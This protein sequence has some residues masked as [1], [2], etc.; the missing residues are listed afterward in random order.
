MQNSEWVNLNIRIKYDAWLRV[1]GWQ[2]PTFNILE[3]SFDMLF[4]NIASFVSTEKTIT[5]EDT[6]ADVGVY[7]GEVRVVMIN[8]N[9]EAT[10]KP[11]GVHFSHYSPGQ[12]PTQQI[13]RRASIEEGVIKTNDKDAATAVTGATVID[14]V[15]PMCDKGFAFDSTQTNC[16]ACTM[17]D[18]EYCTI[19]DINYV[20]VCRSCP[21]SSILCTEDYSCPVDYYQDAEFAT[22]VRLG[23]LVVILL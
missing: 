22:D 13:Y 9:T 6:V 21:E 7:W 3:P 12:L 1:N 19:Q 10:T 16:I 8:D 5:F 18:C 14:I 23:V 2:G 15:V 20:N 4:E 11:W 17:A